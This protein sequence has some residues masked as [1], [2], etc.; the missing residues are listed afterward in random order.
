MPSWLAD[1][2]PWIDDAGSAERWP[3][4]VRRYA[5]LA[6]RWH[7]LDRETWKRLDFAV[8]AICVSEATQH[9]KQEQILKACAD[10]VALCNRAA[11]G[12]MPT[13]QEWSVAATTT[14][15]AAR[16]AAVIAAK[17]VWAARADDAAAD[18]ADT[19]TDATDDKY[20]IMSA[21]LA[22]EAIKWTRGQE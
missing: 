1:L 12:D 4:V 7:V 21:G 19:A 11:A 18:T 14:L 6:S 13:K 3:E 10:V 8:R 20:L 2:T 16:A 17:A 9:T 22:V 5:D 15:T